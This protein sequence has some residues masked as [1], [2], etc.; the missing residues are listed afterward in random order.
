MV[1]VNNDR[2][3]FCFMLDIESD[4]C[5]SFFILYVV[6]LVFLENCDDVGNLF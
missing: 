2:I 4:I 5:I 1:L 6:F 3:Y